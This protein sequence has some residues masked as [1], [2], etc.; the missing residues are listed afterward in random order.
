LGDGGVIKLTA[1]LPKLRLKE[2]SLASVNMSNYGAS[3][4][5]ITLKEVPTLL[6]LNVSTGESI[7]KNK[8]SSEGAEPL[9]L[10][11]NSNSCVIDTL[12]M[13]HLRLGSEGARIAFEGVTSSSLESLSLSKNDIGIKSINVLTQ[14]LARIP[15]MRLDL[16][17][18]NIQDT[19]IKCLTDILGL[20]YSKNIISMNLS[21]LNLSNNAITSQGFEFFC[22]EMGVNRTLETLILDDN[23]LGEGDRFFNIKYYL[24]KNW[25]LK[26]LS[27][28]NISP[29]E[30]DLKFIC[31]GVESNR[32]LEELTLSKN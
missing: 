2:L 17:K 20:F 19:G 10:L 18:N 3:V 24:S 25:G 30:K 29:C 13:N 7:N 1:V 32:S 12:Q 16:S 22:R 8:L 15:L 14:S 4:L 26:K 31:E 28:C 27:L 6:K 9:K 5:F 23:P 21:Y 11:L